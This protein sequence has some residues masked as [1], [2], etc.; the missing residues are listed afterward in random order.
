MKAPN[1][2]NFYYFFYEEVLNLDEPNR[3][4]I[5]QQAAITEG[6]SLSKLNVLN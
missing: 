4:Q 3:S 6:Q 5:N 2:T 1:I